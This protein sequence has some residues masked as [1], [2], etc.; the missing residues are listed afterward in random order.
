MFNIY[1]DEAVTKREWG[2]C[3][4][5]Q[6]KK[7]SSCTTHCMTKQQ[8]PA[9]ERRAPGHSTS[10][11]PCLGT[12]CV[13]GQK[14]YIYDGLGVYADALAHTI[15]NNR[16]PRT[17]RSCIIHVCTEFQCVGL[18]FCGSFSVGRICTS[19]TTGR[20]FHHVPYDAI[21]PRYAPLM[22]PPRTYHCHR[23]ER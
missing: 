9:A 3:G 20:I 17:P 23:C 18:F 12:C 15:N 2:R 10:S 11:R 4:K 6:M 13:Y 7:P 8:Q 19:I 1:V 14:S 22:M 5:R 21:S 16:A